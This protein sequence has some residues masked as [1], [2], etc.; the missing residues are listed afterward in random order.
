MGFNISFGDPSENFNAN[1]GN[2]NEEQ[3]SFTDNTPFVIDLPNG[4]HIWVDFN[5]GEEMNSGFES[6]SN[7]N[8]RFSVSGVIYYDTEEHWNSKRL[9]IAEYK[10]IYVYSNYSYIEDDEG[11][12]VPVPAIKIGDGTSYLIDMPFVGQDIRDALLEHID[13]TTI[14]ITSS[15]REFWN[16]K[17]SAFVLANDPE[18]LILSKTIYM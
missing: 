12:R 17:V 9:I 10:A 14:H 16:N 2:Q 18:R 7:M 3:A 6:T 4:E 1:F 15:E 11:N 13:N 8:A 5:S